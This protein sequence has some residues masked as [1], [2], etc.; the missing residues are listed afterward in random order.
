MADR[1]RPRRADGDEG[2]LG[3]WLARRAQIDRA[4][5]VMFAE[6]RRGVFAQDLVDRFATRQ[7]ASKDAVL[8]GDAAKARNRFE[9]DAIGGGRSPHP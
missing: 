1:D 5:A 4:A 8:I 2:F 6:P 7:L 3:R 9:A